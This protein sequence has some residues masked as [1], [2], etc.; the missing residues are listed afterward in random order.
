[1]A[2][3]TQT[4]PKEEVTEE[5]AEVATPEE[6]IAP[7]LRAIPAP[8]TVSGNDDASKKIGSFI[9]IRD[10]HGNITRYNLDKLKS[11][12]KNGETTIQ[13]GWIDGTSGRMEY[14]NPGDADDLIERLDN[15]CI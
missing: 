11:Y 7:P 14:N 3:K 5:A 15:L 9:G 4:K 12:A 2:N 6:K 13:F 1:M 8:N 10:K